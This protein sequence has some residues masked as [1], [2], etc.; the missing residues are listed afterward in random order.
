[1]FT[2]Y[3]LENQINHKIYIG[4][5]CRKPEERFK[6]HIRSANKNKTNYHLHNS[7]SKYGEDNFEV[8]PLESTNSKREADKLERKFIKQ[9]NTYKKIGYNMTPGGEG[10]GKGEDH[11]MYGRSHTEETKKKISESNKNKNFSK[12]TREKISKA[13]SGKNHHMYGKSHTK[14]AK[15]KISESL[16]GDNHYLYG[17]SLNDEIKEKISK[18]KSH[19]GNKLTKEDARKIKWLGNNSNMTN[20][21]VGSEFNVNASVVSRIKNN[22]SWVGID[23][24]KPKNY[25][26]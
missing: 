24:Q 4:R 7:I 26:N 13:K 18:S 20:N 5:T 6:Q 23:E 9:F 16:S 11:P 2:I 25:N 10:A 14:E 3:L 19:K 1:M 17:K 15:T 12:E 8:I 22:K 21:E